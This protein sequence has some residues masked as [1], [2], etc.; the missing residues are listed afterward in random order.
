[1][2]KRRNCNGTFSFWV[3]KL[4]ALIYNKLQKST[5]NANNKQQATGIQEKPGNKKNLQHIFEFPV[6]IFYQIS[7]LEFI[8]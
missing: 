7:L 1:M 4:K 8:N 3:H 5:K 6:R 2:I